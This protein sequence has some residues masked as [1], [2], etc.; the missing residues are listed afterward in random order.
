[1]KGYTHCG[2]CTSCLL[3][4]QGLDLAGLG[5]IDRES[6]IY[7][8]DLLAAPNA[9]RSEKLHGLRAMDHQWKRLAWAL[10]GGE[11]WQQ[12]SREFPQLVEVAAV[13]PKVQESPLVEDQ[14]VG[15]YR[16]YVDE[17]AAFRAKL[18]DVLAV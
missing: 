6:G 17:W 4:R 8:D 15:L 1:M 5:D 11:P 2:L 9:F 18:L 3:R 10:G 16:R 14:L 13:A 12:L 7:K